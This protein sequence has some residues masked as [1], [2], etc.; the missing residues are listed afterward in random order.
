[1]E[2]AE[3]EGKRQ[4]RTLRRTTQASGVC[5]SFLALRSEGCEQ[6]RLGAVADAR[7]EPCPSVPVVA[8]V[9]LPL[10]VLAEHR[11]R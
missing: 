3:G 10:S 5:A 4:R 7:G 1:M 8:K 11:A 9:T 2:E 6:C